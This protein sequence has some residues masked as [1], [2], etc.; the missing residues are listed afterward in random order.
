MRYYLL[1]ISFLLPL[2]AISQSNDTEIFLFDLETNN[3]KIQIKNGKNISK[4]QG[5]DNQP[6][7][8]DDRY[9]F[10][11]SARNGQIDIA[12]YDTRYDAKIWVNFTEGGEYSPLKIP[13][14][15]EVSAVRLDENGKQQ[16]Y[17][18][19]LSNGNSTELISDLVVAYYTW[20]DENTIVSAVI[21]DKELNLYV[22]NLKAGTHK[23]YASNVGRSFHKIPNSDF[24][25]FISK[26]NGNQ[27]QIKAINPKTGKIK[28]IANTIKG[29][30]DICWL[31]SKTLLSG[32]DNFLYKLRLQRDN[33]WQKIADVSTND[34][35][36]ITRLSANSSG[37]K[38]LIAGD[39]IATEVEET[40]KETPMN[41]DE[42]LAAKVVQKHVDPFNNRQLEAFAN[43][44][45]TNIIVNRFPRAKMYSGRTT[46]IEHY[47]QFF[48][49]NKKSSVKILNRMTLKNMVIDEELVT[50]DNTTNR[51][52]T[53]YETDEY[54]INTMT[55]IENSKTDANPEYIVNEQLE[56]Y[57]NRDISG[58]VK[59]YTNDVMLFTFPYTLNSEGQEPLRAQYA[60]FFKRTPDLYAEIVN[61]IVLGNKVIDKEKVLINGET[62]YAI[63]IYEIRNGLISRV[64]FIQ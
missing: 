53:I 64:T 15:Q 62:F 1:L 25:S 20:F 43:A 47:R 4:N 37:T 56:A 9:I 18:Y 16:L 7:F 26:A 8:L 24:V 52:I 40:T 55:F 38:L 45:D 11:A 17:A 22:T 41:V 54:N 5:Y 48:K 50:V 19:N 63:A 14:K 44:F 46:L 27:W 23:K 60:S 36:K 28:L 35:V 33:N 32:K 6:S 42:D 12:K 49:K 3:S 39:I 30:E 21:E 2:L 58:F 51:Q 61:R 31:N 57:N 13:N 29:V 34:I 59:T 10:F